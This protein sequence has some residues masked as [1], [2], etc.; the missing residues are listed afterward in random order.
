MR[1]PI[2]LFGAGSAVIVEVEESCRRLGRPIHA[3]VKNTSDPSWAQ[4]STLVRTIDQLDSGV[5]D[6]ELIVPLFRPANR[7][8]ALHQAMQLGAQRFGSVIDPTS[9]LPS[10]LRI[11]EGTF[12]NAGC[13]VGASSEIGRFAFINRGCSLGHHLSLGEFASIGPGVAIA[14]QVVI[15]DSAFIGAGAVILPKITV[16]DGAIISAGVVVRHDVAPGVTLRAKQP[17]RLKTDGHVA[18]AG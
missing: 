5:F 12:I 15:G 3:I 2:V 4:D 1:E 13:T 18:Q 8:T 7:R 6:C 10:R 9:I 11:G 17:E 14:G 16:G